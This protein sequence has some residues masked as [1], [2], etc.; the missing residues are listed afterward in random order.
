MV[1]GFAPLDEGSL[2][3]RGFH[4]FLVSMIAPVATGRSESCR[5]GIAPTDTEEPCL[6]TARDPVEIPV[7]RLY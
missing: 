3:T 6:G 5:E 7:A 1:M 4:R 2:P